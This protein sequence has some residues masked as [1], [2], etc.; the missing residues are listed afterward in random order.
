MFEAFARRLPDGRRYG[1]LGG[2]GRLLDLIEGFRFS[3]DEVGWL[4]EQGVVN[5][6]T[7]DYLRDFRFTGDIDAYP[8]G[9]LYFPGSPILTVSGSLG[10][11]IVLETLVLSVLNHDS[12]I[13]SAAAR[14]VTAAQGPAARRDG[15]PAHP[16]GG[17]GRGRPGGVPRRL[18]LDQQPRGRP[19][20]RHPDGRHRRAR[21]HRSPTRARRPRS[22]ARSRRRAPAPRCSWTPSTSPRASAPRWRSPG[23]ASARSGS[24]PATWPRSRRKARALLDELGATATRIIVTSDLDEFVIA[25]LRDA[26]ID[27]YG[28][29]TRVVTGSGHPTAA[30]V[31]KLVAVADGPADA[32]LRPVAKKSAAKVSVGGRKTVHREYADGVSPARPSRSTTPASHVQVPG[33]PRRRRRPP[34]VAPGDPRAR[35]GGAR[36]AARRGARRRRAATPTSPSDP[37]ERPAMTRALLIVDVQNDFVEGGSLARRRRPRGGRAGSATT[38][39]STPTSTRW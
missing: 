28:V 39:P 29:G 3:D 21:V 12:A 26:P 17:G 37:E 5:E 22:A 14:M 8:E 11:C 31:Y 38:S 32:P 1:L 10:E 9:D 30:M 25:A 20:L 24:T 6:A 15:D 4:R 7:A 33:G 27:G 19:S 23:R 18:R 35:R 13:A 16:R 34:P 36:H 2:L